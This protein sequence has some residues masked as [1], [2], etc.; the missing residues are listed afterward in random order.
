MRN[1]MGGK[2]YIFLLDYF[3]L[4]LILLTL[5]LSFVCLIQ[6]KEEKHQN[7]KLLMWT[8]HHRHVLP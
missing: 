7:D 4:L 6:K 2:L 1:R 5:F 8:F 3:Y